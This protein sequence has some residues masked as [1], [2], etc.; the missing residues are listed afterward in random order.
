MARH[1]RFAA[2]AFA[3]L[4]ALVFALA[5]ALSG[6]SGAARAQQPAPELALKDLAGADQTLAGLKGK[7]VL[8]NFWATWC[9]PCRKEM[10][11]LVKLQDEYRDKGLQ[12]VAV[13]V[14]T[15][16]YYD[17]VRAYAADSKLNFPVWFGSTAN[18]EPFGLG[19][20][21]PSTIVVDRQGRVA[22]V[23]EGAIDDA[24]LRKQLDDLLAKAP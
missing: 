21:L 11:S 6:A 5:I 1:T 17:K 15:P 20:A 7:V 18:M 8:L 14:D 22:G 9:A 19:V 3:P 24:A 2:P 4:F 23:I 12:I 16:S 13:T 10:P